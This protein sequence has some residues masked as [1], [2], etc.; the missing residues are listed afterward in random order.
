MVASAKREV[1]AP[2]SGGVVVIVHTATGG[3]ADITPTRLNAHRIEVRVGSGFTPGSTGYCRRG[4]AAV[5]VWRRGGLRARLRGSPGLV[6]GL[7]P[8]PFLHFGSHHL[9][10]FQEFAFASLDAIGGGGVSRPCQSLPGNH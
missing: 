2:R 7:R 10:L 6:W 5:P 1:G 9:N 4:M 3:V 8:W